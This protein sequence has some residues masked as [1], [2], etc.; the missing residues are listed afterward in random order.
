MTLSPNMQVLFPGTCECYL[1]WQKGLFRCDEGYWDG[2]T[3][4]LSRQALH[5]TT[6]VLTRERQQE[7]CLNEGEG[8]VPIVA[9]RVRNPTQCPWGCSFDPWPH[10]VG[11]GSGVVTSCGIVCRYTSDPVWLWHRWEAAA[12]IRPLA[13]E[14]LYAAGVALKRKKREREGEGHV[15]TEEDATCWLLSW[16]K[17]PRAKGCEE[18]GS[19]GWGRKQALP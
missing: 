8:R 5:V 3:A 14:F 10:S 17:G 2:V 6:R 1:V 18:G 16:R 15:A 11:W 7:I 9:Q 19:R 12:L 4:G 13:W